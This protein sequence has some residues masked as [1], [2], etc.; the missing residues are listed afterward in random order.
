M[1]KIYS[2]RFLEAS[3]SV[4]D[5]GN[6]GQL[7]KSIG[8]CIRDVILKEHVGWRISTAVN[9]ILVGKSTGWLR[10]YFFA[11]NVGEGVEV[12]IAV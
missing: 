4:G 12:R 1:F 5:V 8:P 10:K 7:G 9:F 2:T 11:I 6:L 3:N